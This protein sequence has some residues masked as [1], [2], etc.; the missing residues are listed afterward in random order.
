M[1]LFHLI[2]N[3]DNINVGEDLRFFM[4]DEIE[5]TDYLKI[6]GGGGS[7]KHFIETLENSFDNSLRLKIAGERDKYYKEALVFTTDKYIVKEKIEF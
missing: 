3:I 5:E 1:K 4:A 2:K 7:R 6:G